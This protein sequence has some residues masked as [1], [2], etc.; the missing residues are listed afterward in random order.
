MTPRRGCS[1]VRPSSRRCLTNEALPDHN[2]DGISAP[3]NAASLV[4]LRGQ[5]ELTRPYIR[6]TAITLNPRD[7][8]TRKGAD[9]QLAG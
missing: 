4:L 2:R 5:A 8:A 7:T 6:L 1:A 9:P 3:W